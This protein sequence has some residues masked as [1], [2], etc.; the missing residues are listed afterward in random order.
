MCLGINS[1]ESG[2]ASS[3]FFSSVINSVPS[4]FSEVNSS[5]LLQGR[6]FS[7]KMETEAN[8]RVLLGGRA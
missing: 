7:D 2:Q 3:V 8:L 5:V 4:C 1:L 6:N